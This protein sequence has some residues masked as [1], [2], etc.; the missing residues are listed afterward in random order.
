MCDLVDESLK[1]CSVKYEMA[2]DALTCKM[3]FGFVLG[4]KVSYCAIDNML[5]KK[6]TNKI[7]VLCR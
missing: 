3:L 6:I 7:S 2:P 5:D 1:P 4:V